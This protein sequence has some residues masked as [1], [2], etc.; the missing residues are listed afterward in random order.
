MG[1]EA[2]V[3]ADSTLLDLVQQRLVAHTQELSSLAAVPVHLPQRIRDHDAFSRERSLAGDL[4]QA[5]SISARGRRDI[6]RSG[7]I[8][9][10]KDGVIRA[11]VTV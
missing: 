5:T 3:A 4:R 9:V 6:A 11:G 7:I 8:V 10:P 2:S 1:R